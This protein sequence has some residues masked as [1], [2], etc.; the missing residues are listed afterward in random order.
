M[1]LKV[2]ILAK[3]T[4]LGAAPAG[5]G[6]SQSDPPSPS[7]RSNQ[8]P[9]LNSSTQVLPAANGQDGSPNEVRSNG[10]QGGKQPGTGGT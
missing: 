6:E 7:L 3:G 9:D 8:T 5:S 1:C 2:V 10:S 4:G